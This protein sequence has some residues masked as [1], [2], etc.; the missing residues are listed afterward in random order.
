MS[1]AA[2]DLLDQ[3]THLLDV[4]G[5]AWRYFDIG[6]SVIWATTGALRA[7]KHGY[8]LVG[9]FTIALVSSTGGG[10]L[11]DGLFLQ[12]GP[13]AVVRTPIYIAI[14]AAAAFL[15]WAFAHRVPN[16]WAFDRV[17]AF[18]DAIGLG[19][20]SVAGMQLASAVNVSVLGALL[21]GVT[22]AVG[23]SV[24]RSLLMH[25]VP[26][27]FRPGHWMALAVL[28]GCVLYETLTAGFGLDVKLAAAPT[29][30]LIV[31]LRWMSIRYSFRT[32]PA[33]GEARRADDLPAAPSDESDRKL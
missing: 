21:I 29:V 9:I 15:V 24:L 4:A 1:G 31:L 3:T 20:F 18:A 26:E 11:R 8:D 16:L 25:E 30:P 10:L 5:I 7:A 14:A 17:A 33:Y 27:V 13:P 6:A 28:P 12:V 19:G 2:S 23:G 32:R 22:N